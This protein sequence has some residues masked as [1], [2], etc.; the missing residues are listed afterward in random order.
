MMVYFCRKCGKFVPCGEV[1]HGC[2]HEV[3]NKS[4]WT[5]RT[6]YGS[7]ETYSIEEALNLAK[8]GN[9]VEE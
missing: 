1:R 5:T 6:C 3:E 7:I 4:D 9:I 2:D 8:A